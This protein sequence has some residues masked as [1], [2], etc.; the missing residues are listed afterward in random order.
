MG[1]PH[2]CCERTPVIWVAPDPGHSPGVH[3]VAGPLPLPPSSPMSQPARAAEKYTKPL[4][5]HVDSIEFPRSGPCALGHDTHPVGPA[6]H[7]HCLQV[8]G[9]AGVNDPVLTS[10]AGGTWACTPRTRVHCRGSTTG[11]ATPVPSYRWQNQGS[12]GLS[13]LPKVTD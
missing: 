6:P 8:G 3:R 4:P 13:D 5:R 11:A 9:E 2:S 12:G 1:T 10:P 7:V